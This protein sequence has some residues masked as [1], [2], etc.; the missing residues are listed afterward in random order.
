[1]NE[2]ENVIA[3]V[4]KRAAV[5][6][7]V[8]ELI[9]SMFISAITTHS[10]YYSGNTYLEID[11]DEFNWTIFLSLVMINFFGCLLMYAVGEIIDKLDRIE[12]KSSLK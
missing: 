6:L 12:K 9:G 7:F 1:M 3:Q 10:S 8:L 5:V 2:N 11:F 4:V